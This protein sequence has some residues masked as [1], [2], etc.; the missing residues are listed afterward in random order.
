MRYNLRYLL[1]SEWIK[2]TQ[3]C[4]TLSLISLGGANVCMFLYIFHRDFH[5]DLRLIFTASFTSFL[6]GLHIKLQL[7]VL[8]LV[9]FP[10]L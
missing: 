7:K 1:F 3:T 9:N 5:E 4:M 6:A 10:T 8:I 2:A